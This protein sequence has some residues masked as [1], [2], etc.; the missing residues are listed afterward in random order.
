MFEKIKQAFLSFVSNDNANYP[1][2]QASYNN[3]ASNFVR[4]SD[5]LG[6]KILLR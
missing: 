2:G 1:D 4:M 6:R 3:A 5:V